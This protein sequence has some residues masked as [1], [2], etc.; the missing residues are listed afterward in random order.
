MAITS[1]RQLMELLLEISSLTQ[2]DRDAMVDNALFEM[3]ERL[4]G[5]YNR[6]MKNK[7]TPEEMHRFFLGAGA[8]TN[9]YGDPNT[10]EVF[11]DYYPTGRSNP[12]CVPRDNFCCWTGG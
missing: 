5:L 9:Q 11:F 10:P 2:D 6:P 12:P 4:L 3:E 1:R 7:C 8:H